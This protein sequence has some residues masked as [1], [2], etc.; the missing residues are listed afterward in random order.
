[1]DSSG[2]NGP[3]SVRSYTP[4]ENERLTSNLHAVSARVHGR[5]LDARPGTALLQFFHAQLFAEVRDHAG[6]CRNSSFGTEHLTFGP[7]RSVHRSAVPQKLRDTFE[8]CRREL[9]VLTDAQ[10][11][12]DYEERAIWL[13]VW[14]HAEIIRIHPFEDGNGRSSRLMMSHL[15]IET[16]LRPIPI[17]AC[18]QE[19]NDALNRYFATCE[20]GLLLDLF[21]RLYPLEEATPTEA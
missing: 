14:T 16:G 2:L 19:Y 11:A 6:R 20:R 17:E 3:D 5:S 21:L 12:E 10:Q 7:N 8:K 9:R 13:A 4:E 1:M 18:K 15:L